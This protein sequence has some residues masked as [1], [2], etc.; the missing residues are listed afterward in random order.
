VVD[1]AIALERIE[2]RQIPEPLLALAHHQRRWAAG[3]RARGAR[4]QPGEQLERGGLSG[5]V[6]ARTLNS[7]ACTAAMVWVRRCAG[8][9]RASR[10]PEPRTDT[11]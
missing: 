10:R 7:S 4:Q 1:G 11:P 8:L 9:R 3:I 6:G 2:H 5:A